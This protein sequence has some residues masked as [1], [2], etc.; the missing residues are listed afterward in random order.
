MVR[1]MHLA[2]NPV[3]CDYLGSHVRCGPSKACVRMMLFVYFDSAQW[4]EGLTSTHHALDHGQ[5]PNV[6]G[7]CEPS[8]CC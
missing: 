7:T 3:D 5:E 1:H 8:D 6:C 2:V 4:S